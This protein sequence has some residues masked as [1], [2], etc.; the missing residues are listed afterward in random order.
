[1][2]LNGAQIVNKIP[3]INHADGTVTQGVASNG[4]I[5]IDTGNL[6][7][8]TPQ[9]NSKY[10]GNNYSVNALGSL[11]IASIGFGGGKPP[12][13]PYTQG[14]LG[15]DVKDIHNNYQSTEQT[16]SGIAE[17]LAV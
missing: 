6:M 9:N 17:V 10:D 8:T 12:D 4:S 1:M 3:D 13:V 15:G 16:M 14:I 5:T 2:T 7:I 11:P